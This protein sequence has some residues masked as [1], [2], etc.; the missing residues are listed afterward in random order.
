MTGEKGTLPVSFT[1]M[2]TSRAL[3]LFALLAISQMS[4]AVSPDDRQ[5]DPMVSA[6]VAL[7]SDGIAASH[8]EIRGIR[9]GHI[10]GSK[11]LDAI[12][13]LSIEGFGGGN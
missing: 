9:F 4:F 7:F 1:T 3:F 2:N 11:S 8:P 5:I 10:F 12:A 6:L 13:F